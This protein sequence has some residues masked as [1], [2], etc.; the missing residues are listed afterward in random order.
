[1]FR[2]AAVAVRGQSFA[3]F[4][5]G[6]ARFLLFRDRASLLFF[7]SHRFSPVQIHSGLVSFGTTAIKFIRPE[8]W[9]GQ[10]PD[11]YRCLLKVIHFLRE[12]GRLH[13]NFHMQIRIRRETTGDD[14][15]RALGVTHHVFCDAADQGMLKSGA[16][17]SGSDDEINFGLARCG[18]DFVD[19]V[20][21]AEFRFE[22]ASRAKNPSA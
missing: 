7:L 9:R 13:C 5:F 1:M 2:R 12:P 10:Q 17:M 18:T 21:G 14:Q 22:P 20:A 19:R 4:A 15:H 6:R 8:N 3:F 16:A 11:A